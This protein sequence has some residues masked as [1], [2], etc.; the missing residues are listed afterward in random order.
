MTT[1]IYNNITINQELEL[2]GENID[3]IVEGIADKLEEM[4]LT[5]SS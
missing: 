3:D 1:P 4:N 2:T 5:N